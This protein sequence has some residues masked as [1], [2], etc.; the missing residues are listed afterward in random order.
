MIPHGEI[1]TNAMQFNA[2]QLFPCAWQ[3]QNK[4]SYQFENLL[5]PSNINI[6][7]LS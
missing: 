1:F 4:I 7:V 3:S 5:L 2:M 6:A